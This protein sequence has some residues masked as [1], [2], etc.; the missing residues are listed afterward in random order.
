MKKKLYLTVAMTS[1]ALISYQV[2]LMH[3]L[4]IAQWHHFAYMIISAAMLGFGASGTLLALFKDRKVLDEPFTVFSLLVAASAAILVSTVAIS[5]PFLSFDSYRA[6]SE[7]EHMLRVVFSYGLFFIPVLAGALVIALLFVKHPS[8]TSRL[9]FANL[10]GSAAGASAPLAMISNCAPER[11]IPLVS[12][13]PLACAAVMFPKKRKK[14]AALILFFAAASVFFLILRPP[15]LHISQ[16]KGIS[17]ALNQPGSEII[18][19]RRTIYGLLEYVKTPTSRFAPGLSLSYG[20]DIPR[21]DTIF[22]N[23]EE[24]G[25]VFKDKKDYDIFDHT[26]KALVF[27]LASPQSVLVLEEGTFYSAFFAQRQNVENIIVCDP[28]ADEIA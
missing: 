13:T 4:S 19:C 23:S 10:L 22:L 21:A 26:P 17:Y 3:V 2:I 7:T 20:G 11:L 6:L 1:A 24:F 18:D 15:S 27:K 16:Y 28:L 9:Y 8:H 12:L 14:Y 25:P 5:S